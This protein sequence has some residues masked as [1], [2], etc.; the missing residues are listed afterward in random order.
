MKTILLLL[1]GNVIAYTQAQTLR[2]LDSRQGIKDFTLGDP[3]SKW[4]NS[5]QFNS[6]DGEEILYNYTGSCC[7]TIF[8]YG[9]DLINLGFKNGNLST[10]IFYTENFQKP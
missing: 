8:G 9:V 5:L 4:S 1:L 6:T 3:L 2:D 10:I 7:Q